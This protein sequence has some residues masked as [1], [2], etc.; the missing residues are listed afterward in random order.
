MQVIAAVDTLSQLKRLPLSNK[1]SLLISQLRIPQNIPLA[2]RNDSL[3]ST[4]KRKLNPLPYEKR[5]KKKMVQANA[6]KSAEVAFD[7]RY[8][9]IH[10]DEETKGVQAN[11]ANETVQ[12]IISTA[13]SV[14]NSVPKIVRT[15]LRAR[16]L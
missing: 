8:F 2:P 11:G 14:R 7:N 9:N 3:L 15:E 5:K 10:T 16:S 12:S 4:I 6:E 1:V 13:L